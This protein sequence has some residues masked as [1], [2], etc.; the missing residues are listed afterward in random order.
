MPII[1]ARVEFCWHKYWEAIKARGSTL[2]KRDRD[3]ERDEER[4]RWGERDS[5]CSV[6]TKRKN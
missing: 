6:D 2:G 4:N 5:L 1:G 3:R